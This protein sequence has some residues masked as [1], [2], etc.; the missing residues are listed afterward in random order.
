MSDGISGAFCARELGAL[1]RQ[2][3]TAEEAFTALVRRYANLVYS[4][5]SRRFSNRALAEEAAQVVFTRLATARPKI[6]TDPELAAWLHRTTVHVSIDLWRSESRRRTRELAAAMDVPNETTQSWEEIAPHLDE[7]LNE[8]N[9][10]DRQ[11]LLLRFLER[12]SMIEIGRAFAISE[13]AAKMRVSRALERLRTQL[14]PRAAA[15][16]AVALGAMVAE[17]SIEAAPPALLVRLGSL[18]SIG[19]TT[20]TVEPLLQ[21]TRAKIIAATG[22]VITVTLL[23]VSRAAIHDTASQK[24]QEQRAAVIVRPSLNSNRAAAGNLLAQPLPAPTIRMLF[25]LLD[26]ETDQGVAGAHIRATYFYA[27]GRGEPQSGRRPDR[28]RSECSAS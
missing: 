11:V 21:T 19:T 9:D 1:Y 16:T 15:L 22:L 28:H 2:K 7:A 23:L 25:R 10:A 24:Q 5:A 18:H 6:A 12:K 3:L 14:L 13:D 26:A 17:R 8:L 20:A 4:V 27:G